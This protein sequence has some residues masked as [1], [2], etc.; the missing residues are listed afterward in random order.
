MV[1]PARNEEAW[2]PH[3]LEALARQT[4]RPDEVIVV[5]N[6]STDRTAHI[7]RDWGARVLRC[8]TP[9]VAY[10]RQTGL[11]AARGTWVVTTDADSM[12]LPHWLEALERRMPGSVALY[13]PLRFYGVR[14]WEA[15]LSDVGYRGFVHVMRLLGRPNLA[16]ANMAFERAAALEVGGY[17][18]VPAREDVLLG[19]R[20][21]KRGRVRYVPEALVLTSARRLR[22]GWGR[23]LWQQLKNLA[24]RTDT[25]FQE[26]AG[27]GR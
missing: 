1:I 10:A 13:G 27:R 23:F 26:D 22:R 12:P 18:E 20:L 19:W 17:P 11:M 2:L 21:A 7:A 25:Y 4:R 5:D 15:W 6:A 8:D 3:T 16:G 24:G 9:G 14:G